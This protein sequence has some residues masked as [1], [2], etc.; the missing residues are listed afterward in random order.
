LRRFPEALRKLDHVVEITPED[1]FP[2]FLKVAIAQ[3]EGD[4]PRGA[5]LLAQLHLNARGSNPMEE[6][7]LAIQAILERRTAPNIARLKE[8][9][10]KPNPELGSYIGE[11]RFWL[12]WAQGVAGDHGGAKESWRQA[13]R[14]LE[15]FLK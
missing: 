8:I 15:P 12:G 3:E 5:T 7:P 13:R 10:A 4:L 1:V 14:E 9:L 6:L 11:L 2:T